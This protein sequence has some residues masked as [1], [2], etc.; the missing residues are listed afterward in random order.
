[1]QMRSLISQWN[2]R[3]VIY[4][5]VPNDVIFS[6]ALKIYF[7]TWRLSSTDLCSRPKHRRNHIIYQ[8]YQIKRNLNINYNIIIFIPREICILR[9]GRLPIF[10]ICFRFIHSRG[11]S[12]TLIVTW[13]GVRPTVGPIVG[14]TVG[15]TVESS[16]R[17]FNYLIV[18][19]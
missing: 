11:R 18:Q 8:F 12:Y 4:H 2:R 16:K 14:P 13:T 6:S 10:I 15:T 1:M 17:L 5:D 19:I 9:F 3:I 7:Q